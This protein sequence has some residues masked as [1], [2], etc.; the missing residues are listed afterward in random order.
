MQVDIGVP[1]ICSYIFC[2]RCRG[3]GPLNGEMGVR[4]GQAEAASRFEASNW[5]AVSAWALFGKAY[6]VLSRYSGSQFPKQARWETTS[7]FEP[8]FRDALSSRGLNRKLRPRIRPNSG[9]RF[10]EPNSSAHKKRAQTGA[11]TRKCRC[12]KAYLRIK[13]PRSSMASQKASAKRGS[14]AAMRALVAIQPE[15]VPVS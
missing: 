14:L 10:P 7:Q 11:C 5:D 6:P 4:A 13:P 12:P 8:I 3:L 1:N 2:E 9:T 15:G